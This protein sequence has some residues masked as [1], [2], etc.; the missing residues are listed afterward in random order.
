MP[1]LVLGTAKFTGK[2]EDVDGK[3]AV[4]LSLWSTSPFRSSFALNGGL[5]SSIRGPV[6]SSSD[7]EFPESKSKKNN[8]DVF[9]YFF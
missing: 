3:A 4:R 7:E 6:E 5:P 1:V 8:L 9:F 2:V